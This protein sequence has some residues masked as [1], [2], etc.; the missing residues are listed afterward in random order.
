[1]LGPFSGLNCVTCTASL[2]Q[3]RCYQN[4]KQG[5]KRKW[6]A[7]V[8]IHKKHVTVLLPI[9]IVDKFGMKFVGLWLI[10]LSSEG[11]K[12]SS[13]TF[14]QRTSVWYA[15]VLAQYQRAK[16]SLIYEHSLDM[17]ATT[18]L[19]EIYP[20]KDT[21]GVKGRWLLCVVNLTRVCNMHW[22]CTLDCTLNCPQARFV[23]CPI[24]PSP[25]LTIVLPVYRFLSHLSQT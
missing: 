18:A 2:H 16:I 25:D 15:D 6:D 3:I 22:T 13:K 20:S 19:T 8:A 1:M 10:C 7:K 21:T 5:R 17:K 12:V 9:I 11:L 14:R 24:V 23:Y 4:A